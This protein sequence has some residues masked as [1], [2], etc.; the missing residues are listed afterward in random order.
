M[1]SSQPPDPLPRAGAGL[2]CG[3]IG[4]ALMW[5]AGCAPGPLPELSSA[6]PYDGLTNV[7][8]STWI[9]LVFAEPVQGALGG[10]FRV[11]CDGQPVVFDPTLV[12]GH[13]VV[14]N[15][16]ADLPA[17]A[18][19]EVRW[20]GPEGAEV[21]AFETSDP[22]EA[23][24]VHYDR[25]DP[26]A[27]APFPDDYFAVPDASTSTGWRLD[28]SVPDTTG[29]LRSTFEALVNLAN[30]ADGFSPVSP[31]VV[32][33]SELSKSFPGSADSVPSEASLDPLSPV[34]LLDVDSASPTFAERVPFT[35]R[36]RTDAI[37]DGG[38]QTSLVVFPGRPLRAG[39]R[40]AFVI[41]RQLVGLASRRG[42][43]P[44]AF[45][46]RVLA[47]PEAG[48]PA[49][50]ARARGA[51]ADI[52]DVLA[53]DIVPPLPPDDLAL[54]VGIQV[55]SS[56]TFDDD[57]EAIREDVMA[58]PIPG[59]TVQSIETTGLP[60][61]MA[62]LVEGAWDAPSFLDG[63][64]LARAADGKPARQ[65]AVSIP[66][67]LA[68]PETP[69]GGGRAPVALF[70]HGNPG[71][72]RDSILVSGA[73]LTKVGF[74][75][76]GAT[77]VLNRGV[78]NEFEQTIRIL[79]NLLST[80]RLPDSWTQ[81][82]AEQMALV[83]MLEGM[84]TLDVLPVGSPDGE[85]DLDLSAPP[86][87]LGIGEG[88]THALA[89]LPFLPEVRA[90]A[91]VDPSG[92]LGD[93]MIQRGV[94]PAQLAPFLPGLTPLDLWVGLSLFQI[95]YDPQEAQNLAPLLY[96]SPLDL[97]AGG[98]RASL[99]VQQ[100]L[101]STTGSATHSAVVA[102]GIPNM[103]PVASPIPLVPELVG[104]ARGNIDASTTA[105]LDQFRG[106]EPPPSP[107]GY[108]TGNQCV[109]TGAVAVHQRAEFLSSALLDPAPLIVDARADSDGDGLPD[110]EERDAGTDST[111]P[112]SDGDGMGDGFEVRG[113][114]D[115][116]V[117]DA[118]LDPDRDGLINRQEHDA[119]TDPRSRDTDRDGIDDRPE[120]LYLGADP[121][122]WDSDGDGLWDSEELKRGTD[123][124]VADTDGDGVSDGDEVSFRMV[125]TDPDDLQHDPDAD[126]LSS[127]EELALGTRPD[128]KDTDVDGLADGFE[129]SLGT[130]PLDPD[131][132]DGGRRDGTEV[133]DDGTDP[134]D[135]EDDR[136]HELDPLVD[137]QGFSWHLSWRGYVLEGDD[138]AFDDGLALHGYRLPSGELVTSE[139]EGRERVFPPR[140]DLGRSRKVF[141]P[142][143]A[144]FARFL[145]TVPAT[146]IRVETEVGSGS[147]T[148]VA[149][150]SSGDALVDASDDYIVFAGVGSRPATALVFSSPAASVR[151]SRVELDA[152]GRFR[153]EYDL[154][155][156]A[157]PRSLLHYAIKGADVATV[158]T[159]AEALLGLMRPAMGGLSVDEFARVVNFDIGSDA[160]LDGVPGRMEQA[161]GLDATNPDTDGD[162]LT[163]GFELRHG[164]SA[165]TWDDSAA[166]PDADG[167]SDTRE[168][169]WGTHPRDSDSDDDGLPD[170]AEVDVHGTDPLDPDTD[171]DNLLDGWEILHGLNAFDPA[172]RFGDPDDDG[173]G[174]PAEQVAGTDPF[175]EDTDGD[176]IS[177]YLEVAA[178][179]DPLDPSDAFGDRDG[180]GLTNVEEAGLGTDPALADTDFDGLGDGVEVEIFGTDPLVRDTDGDGTSDGGEILVAADPLDPDTDG[181]GI[182]DYAEI[183]ERLDPVDPHDADAD[184]DGD[185]LDNR[186]EVSLGTR[187]DDPDTDGDGLWDGVEV[188]VHGSNPL[189]RDGDDGGRTDLQ[190]VVWDGTDPLLRVDDRVRRSLPF[191]IHP[192]SIQRHGFLWEWQSFSL[193]SFVARG[194]DFPKAPL[195]AIAEGSLLETALAPTAFA[196]LHWQRKVFA[197]LD[198]DFVRVLDIFENR[199]SADVAR[200][201]TMATALEAV[202]NALVGESS[203]DGELGPEDDYFVIDDQDG[204]PY[205]ALVQVFSGPGAPLEPVSVTS[206][207]GPS[208]ELT[209]A[210]DLDVPAGE[211]A[212][213]LQ[214]VSLK[215]YR[216]DAIVEAGNLL[217]PQGRAL[218][219]MDPE[220][221]RDVVNFALAGD[222]DGDGVGDA[223]DVCP[224][225][226]DP[227][228]A[229][230]DGDGVGDRC[231][232]CAFDPN[233]DQRDT[234]GDG[235]GNVCDPDFDQDLLVEEDD[236]ERLA[237]AFGTRRG[238]PDFELHFDLDGD[239]VVGLTDFNILRDRFGVGPGPSALPCAL[240][241]EIDRCFPY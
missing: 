31:I 97:G 153:V 126:G 24:V 237:E 99:L 179:L 112:D 132:D 191:G 85:P 38:T 41:T 20:Q 1:L 174:N 6:T 21:I 139:E 52:L 146:S 229:D 77:D 157:G 160:D 83:R 106:L 123:P 49:S 95:G 209:F 18:A 44:S 182:S 46:A 195:I 51:I 111:N 54:V 236:L 86:V 63:N 148:V 168:Q 134:F 165:V 107:C 199:G 14:L 74:A 154:S 5:L 43:E 147:A 101:G 103:S 187:L 113:G 105:A 171:S 50:V 192:W 241:G 28:V 201:I 35:V 169:D 26:R 87:Y 145:E 178:L 102:L 156:Q 67:V 217:R 39:G 227:A 37:P 223:D 167:L 81:T 47:D 216:V 65:G 78:E 144:G 34:A 114:L 75:V 128:R 69:F 30:E 211:R 79:L 206:V 64:N 72:A 22:G 210:F 150:T 137:G 55:R 27:L 185:G 152:W 173:L 135:P 136:S 203:G 183:R 196:G 76:L 188:N 59:F 124:L 225:V 138:D 219:D 207:T 3:A 197:P 127:A 94:T 133:E 73:Q 141:V 122:V 56:E 61:G 48:E 218:F 42:F 176:G 170:G 125:P 198:E 226:A 164:L 68:L 116:L 104:P 140:P 9:E 234:R 16:S 40:Y 115:P 71:N 166:D 100:G 25:D 208:G 239:G 189:L 186:R 29:S 235:F 163:D 228:Q 66:F 200:T 230:L 7:P 121:L 233:P 184:R 231:D 177:D 110:F 158:Q 213:L 117:D 159:Q 2:R 130:D 8:V 240:R 109:R 88:A 205:R 204:L 224:T 175:S 33:L 90:A 180:D 142:A 93:Y 238:E 84:A 190:E 193:A 215:P 58:G 4:L 119:G 13:R 12:D 57:L 181:D 82:R 232:N 202:P 98:R 162:G 11:E 62:A 53:A 36:R 172:D 149:S 214:F 143:S 80:G 151:P 70:Q 194:V 19:C 161:H 129:L 60:Q 17:A 108:Q 92:R 91:I 212:I 222:A 131:T 89:V 10:R 45:F 155:A 118:G 15:P 32:Q 120:V 220:E 96:R 23:P 221:R